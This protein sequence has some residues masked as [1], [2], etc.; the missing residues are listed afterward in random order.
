MRVPRLSIKSIL[1]VFVIFGVGYMFVFV[2]IRNRWIEQKH[3][4]FYGWADTGKSDCQKHRI[5]YSPDRSL[6]LSNDNP[7]FYSPNGTTVHLRNASNHELP[8]AVILNIKKGG[9][10]YALWKNQQEALVVC[11]RCRRE[12]LW[13]MNTSA[14]GVNVEI[15]FEAVNEPLPDYQ[16]PH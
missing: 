12:D 4:E 8:G 7:C 11:R 1:F 14:L 10:V 16:I 13:E 3:P 6:I 5:E 2:P 9:P 15:R